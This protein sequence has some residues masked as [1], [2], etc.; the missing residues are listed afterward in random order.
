VAWY[1]N[2][3]VK[4]TLGAMMAS[5]DDYIQ[6]LVTGSTGY[7]A[8]LKNLNYPGA[9]IFGA[10]A[11]VRWKL[12][13]L[14][15]GGSLGIVDTDYSGEVTSLERDPFGNVR[16]IT[17][18]PYIYENTGSGFVSWTGRKWD[19]S[20]NA[21][22]FGRQWIQ[23]LR[24]GT[25]SVSQ[26]LFPTPS[27]WSVNVRGERRVGRFRCF[28]GVDNLLD[29]YQEDLGDPLVHAKWGLQRGRYLYAGAGVKF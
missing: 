9:D 8:I 10:E 20:F 7:N 6:S 21:D 29:E 25:G 14:S 23:K 16:V 5:F 27:Y 1:P 17:I 28:A 4:V 26:N 3:R 18:L 13:R 19:A 22:W 11:G 15:F 12:D 2:N 24:E